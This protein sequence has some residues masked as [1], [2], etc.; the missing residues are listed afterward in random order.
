[1]SMAETVTLGFVGTGGIARHHLAQLSKLEGVRIGA[2]WDV[3]EA[4]AR[5]AAGKF[6][7][8]VYSDYSQMLEGEKL[9]GVYVCVPPAAHRS[10][11]DGTPPPEILAAERGV[12]LFVEKPVCLD[13]E[14]G[15]RIRDAIE[16]A[17]VLSSV[18]YGAR[19]SAA[20]D[21]TQ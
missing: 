15:I 2:V 12:H 4:R 7:G 18:G 11:E 5:E 21:A 17:G 3:V 10:R 14:E 8:A 1:M 13:L 9:D 19:Y 20:A 16:R 6:G